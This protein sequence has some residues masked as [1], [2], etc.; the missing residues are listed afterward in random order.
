MESPTTET[1]KAKPIASVKTKRTAE[2]LKLSTTPDLTG[3]PL[4]TPAETLS[5]IYKLMLKVETEKSSSG[6]K[7]VN[8][9]DSIRQKNEQRHTEL[10]SVLNGA[11]V[12]IP[13]QEEPE[14]KTKEVSKKLKKLKTPKVKKT[15]AKVQKVAKMEAAKPTATKKTPDASILGSL[16]KGVAAAA[17]VGG[18]MAVTSG[19][20]LAAAIT[21]GE[22]Y[23]GDPNA[24]NYKTGDKTY[25]PGR[26]ETPT[27]KKVTDMTV[28][29]IK[30]AQKSGKLHAVGKWQMIPSTFKDA[31]EKTGLSENQ[32]FDEQT[33]DKMF[34]Y[35]LSQKKPKIGKY[36][37]GDPSVTR[38]EAIIEVA[39]EWA[40]V[41]VPIDMRGAYKEI[42]KGESYYS[43][44]GVN[45]ASTSPDLIGQMLDDTRS[46]KV[47]SAPPLPTLLGHRLENESKDNSRM[48][49]QLQAQSAAPSI[50]N[51]TINNAQSTQLSAKK[52][53]DDRSAY[54]RKSSN[55]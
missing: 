13:K 18:A 19:S 16:G 53:E 52:T 41:G 44:D 46:K 42:K 5:A 54:E 40:S 24:F 9:V 43:G 49:E 31:V 27:G 3:E 39:K 45:K 25:T 20:S 51:T 15:R 12:N 8:I 28:G 34:E 55:R 32:K 4:S 17:V 29:E 36:L 7:D 38:D 14:D 21:S 48:Y 47:V 1:T 50:N 2:A 23:G 22:S 33:Q 6:Y 11:G 37:N 35:F 30:E 10:L 26:K